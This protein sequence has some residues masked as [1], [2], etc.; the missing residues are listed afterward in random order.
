MR[1]LRYHRTIPADEESHGA[2]ESIDQADALLG[3]VTYDEYEFV[4]Q[5]GLVSRPEFGSGAVAMRYEPRS[6][7]LA[8]LRVSLIPRVA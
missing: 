2:I 6:S 4:V 7:S 3:R 1:R 8:D 5:S